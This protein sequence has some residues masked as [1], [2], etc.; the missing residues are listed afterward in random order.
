MGTVRSVK[1]ENVIAEEIIWVG[2]F[3]IV[4][5][6][7]RASGESMNLAVGDQVKTVINSTEVLV[8]TR[9]AVRES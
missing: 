2:E 3:E 8:D 4:S 7:T 9:L 6:I 5:V 1:L